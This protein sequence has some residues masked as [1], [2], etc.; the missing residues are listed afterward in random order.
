MQVI[1]DSAKERFGVDLSGSSPMVRG[2]FGQPM[3]F[4]QF[5]AFDMSNISRREDLSSGAIRPRYVPMDPDGD[6]VDQFGT[7]MSLFERNQGSPMTLSDANSAFDKGMSGLK[8]S[9]FGAGGSRIAGIGSFANIFNQPV[10]MMQSGGDPMDASFS[11]FAGFDDPSDPFGGGDS[12]IDDLNNEQSFVD[13]DP[14]AG[15]DFTPGPGVGG[16]SFDVVSTPTV[17]GDEQQEKFLDSEIFVGTPSFPTGRNFGATP[18]INL[19]GD[20]LEDIKKNI[21][22]DNLNELSMD[23]TLFKDNQL[24]PN[25]SKLS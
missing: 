8:S 18:N 17:T 15:S 20:V 5:P 9:A 19:S 25:G 12:S 2:D 1:E 6:G 16:G 3:G 10:A 22:I 4:N 23:D 7:K 13:D 14:V 21:N 11:D 24:T